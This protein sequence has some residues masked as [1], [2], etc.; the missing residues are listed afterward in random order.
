[1]SFYILFSNLRLGIRLLVLLTDVKY[2]EVKRKLKQFVMKES[3]VALND[4]LEA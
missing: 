3:M 4:C 1:M 2:F